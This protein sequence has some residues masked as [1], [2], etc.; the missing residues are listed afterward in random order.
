MTNTRNFEKLFASTGFK[1]EDVYDAAVN[2]CKLRE[3][4]PDDSVNIE[5]AVDEIIRHIQLEQVVNSKRSGY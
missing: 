5:S 2:L 4:S 1:K 3:I